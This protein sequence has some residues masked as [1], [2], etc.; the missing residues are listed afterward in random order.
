MSKIKYLVGFA[1]LL[2]MVSLTISACR[3]V[4][5]K[6]HQEWKA[7]FEKN[8]IQD[9]CFEIYDNNK[10]IASYFNKARCA[11]RMTPG[12]VFDIFNALTALSSNVALDEQ[13]KLGITDSMT[14]MTDSL[15][16]V[17]AFKQ[18]NS[19]YF[20]QLATLIDSQKMQFSLDTIQFGNRQMGGALGRFYKNGHL[21]ITADEMVGFMKRVYHGEL[22]AFDQRSI[23]LVQGMLLKETGTNEKLYYRYADIP[24]NDSTLHWLVGYMEH[25]EVL[26]N[27]KTGKDD[28]I[29]H[30]YFFAMNF[31][32]AK[33]D[34]DWQPV[35]L[36]I[37]KDILKGSHTND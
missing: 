35:S 26:K 14:G 19:A 32:T 3:N 28:Y 17:Q 1:L 4:R 15:T 7:Y 16:L 30:P 34:K 29:P 18:E 27:P 6:E 2:V 36:Q 20:E 8:D 23:R 12:A 21:K 22:P 11:E 33:S 5:I 25:T 37:V 13:F 10:E 31:T 9:A 24:Q